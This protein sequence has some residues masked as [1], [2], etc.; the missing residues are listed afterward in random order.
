MGNRG[1]AVGPLVF[2]T[3]AAL[4]AHCTMLRR[5]YP[6]GVHTG[7]ADPLRFYGETP[8][9]GEDDAFL[10]ALAT[11][12]P[13]A[14]RIIGTGIDRIF[15]VVNPDYCDLDNVCFWVR[16]SDGTG[17]SLSYRECITP[18][19]VM[20][21]IEQVF[22]AEVEPFI[23]DFLMKFFARARM[24][25]RDPVC[26]V[27]GMSLDHSKVVVDHVAPKTF[28]FLL[29]RFLE[30]HRVDVRDVEIVRTGIGKTRR[31]MADRAL[32][33]AWFDYHA[34]EADLRVVDA[35]THR[36]FKRC[37]PPAAPK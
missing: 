4:A 18:S 11:R 23:S 32:A 27:T 8:F 25:L 13:E 15:A 31:A 37:V 6:P 1:Y 21:N 20:A 19:P 3:K 35:D 7:V 9:T 28:K 29:L 16:R 22:R 24:E 36:R 17:C 10:R 5:K 12:H 26:S 33:K 34:K 30:S 14:G 2:K